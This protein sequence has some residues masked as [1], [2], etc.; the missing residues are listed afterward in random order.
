[1]SL[2]VCLCVTRQS[3]VK[4]AKRRITP[5]TPH[6]STGTLVFWCHRSR[7]NSNGVTPKVSYK[8]WWGRLKSANFVSFSGV[9]L[10]RFMVTIYNDRQWWDGIV[11]LIMS[12]Y[13]DTLITGSFSSFH[14]TLSP[15]HYHLLYTVYATIK[16]SHLRRVLSTT[17]PCYT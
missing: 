10:R 14:P 3:C 6:D 12:K 9:I 5:T 2:C 17:I 13:I 16:A 15:D 8:W 1:M 4:T 11:I 7:R